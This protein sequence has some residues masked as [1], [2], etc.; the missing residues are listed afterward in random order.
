LGDGSNAGPTYW[1][2][3]EI[4]FMA[5]ITIVLSVTLKVVHKRQS[6]HRQK[7][8][9]LPDGVKPRDSKLEMASFDPDFIDLVLEPLDKVC[10]AKILDKFRNF[11]MDT[12]F[13]DFT[14][15]E[16]LA[17][18]DSSLQVLDLRELRLLLSRYHMNPVDREEFVR[19]MLALSP[20]D[21][22]HF[23]VKYMEEVN[24]DS[25]QRTKQVKS[26]LKALKSNRAGKSQPPHHRARL[27]EKSLA[28]SPRTKFPTN[29]MRWAKSTTRGTSSNV[30]KKP[31]LFNGIFFTIYY[32]IT[33]GPKLKVS[34]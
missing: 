5:G 28:G 33:I 19:E 25:L 21:R 2:F 18:L 10:M 3:V 15:P 23:L 4:G 8:A 12:N 7:L 14:D 24:S 9:H 32:S 16:M 31:I 22:K 27:D 30:L 17:F 26:K 34:E 1:R 20:L 13:E 29:R 11:G 6:A